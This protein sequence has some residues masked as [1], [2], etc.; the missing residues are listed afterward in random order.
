VAREQDP[1][2]ATSGRLLPLSRWR[3]R[4]VVGLFWLIAAGLAARPPAFTSTW[5]HLQVGQSAMGQP[6]PIRESIIW[7][8][9]VVGSAPVVTNSLFIAIQ[10]V[11]GLCLVT[12]RHQRLAIAA[13]VP[14]ALGIWWVGEGLG[15]VPT[16]FATLS[17]GAP[18]AAVLYPALSFFAWPPHEGDADLPAAPRSARST[19][20]VLW[21]GQ[22]VLLA[23]W[24]FPAGQVLGATV[25][26]NSAGPSWVTGPVASVGSF[27]A[28]HGPLVAVGLSAVSAVVGLSVTFAATKRFGLITGLI[29]L[30]LFWIVF[31]GGAGVFTGDATDVGTAP[32]V[33]VLAFTLWPRAE[34]TNGVPA[35]LTTSGGD[36]VRSRR[37]DSW[38]ICGVGRA[39]LEMA[40]DRSG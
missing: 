36:E 15:A 7:A 30:G 16:G 2:R 8:V 17:G 40:E 27:F 12:G 28:H 29:L 34:H 32:L 18:G 19:W 24:R 9:H 25:E 38:L 22:A 10:A 4:Q 21:C 6:T 5:W 11:I 35:A 37:T 20:L 23:P 39:A 14:M 13:S 26:A 3:V 31:Q 1:Y 33:A